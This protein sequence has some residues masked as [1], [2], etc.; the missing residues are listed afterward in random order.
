MTKLQK[1]FPT[2]ILHYTDTDT[3]YFVPFQYNPAPGESP[4][5]KTVRFS[6]LGHSDAYES[7]EEVIRAIS[8]LTHYIFIDAIW[9]SV[10]SQGFST[11]IRYSPNVF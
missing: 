5:D 7:I 6:S 3:F 4:K 9:E 1:V 2:G 10:S 8:K 11:E